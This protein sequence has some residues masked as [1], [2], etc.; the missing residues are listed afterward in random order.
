MARGMLTLSHS[1]RGLLEDWAEK[2]C[3][4]LGAKITDQPLC[5]AW[6]PPKT[7]KATSPTSNTPPPAAPTTSPV[8]NTPAPQ[9]TRTTADAGGGPAPPAPTPTASN[10]DSS[11]PSQNTGTPG[12]GGTGS[13]GSADTTTTASASTPTSGGE[14][15]PEEDS[16]GG[17]STTGQGT[18]GEPNSGTTNTDSAVIGIPTPRVTTTTD[19]RGNTIVTTIPGA[20]GG[21]P[22]MGFGAATES[23]GLPSTTSASGN[24]GAA[25]KGSNTGAVVGGILGALAVIAILVAAF[26]VIRRRRRRNHVA[27][28]SEFMQRYRNAVT[29]HSPTPTNGHYQDDANVTPA[30]TYAPGQDPF[31]VTPEMGPRGP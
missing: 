30:Y 22:F 3:K 2:Q 15:T 12:E 14:S 18:G 10:S 17:Q 31:A 4:K 23:G 21:D 11:G 16:N 8:A 13:G 5:R 7:T 27:P 1:K 26:L 24:V 6:W 9:V 29:L 20:T 19:S 28:S 25:Q